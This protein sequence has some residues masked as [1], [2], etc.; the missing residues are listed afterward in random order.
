DGVI[1]FDM[2]KVSMIFDYD[3]GRNSP[4]VEARGMHWGGGASKNGDVI[5]VMFGCLHDQASEWNVDVN[6]EFTL[7]NSDSKK[8]IVA[9]LSETMSESG[10][11]RYDIPLTYRELLDEE[12][13]FIK[14]DTITLE[15]RFWIINMKGIRAVPKLDFT[16][17]NISMHDVTLVIEGEKIYVSKQYLSLH[18]PVFQTMFY[19]EFV[20]KGK[21]EIELKDVKREEFIELLHV[22][23]PSSKKI[24]HESAEFLLKL[25]DR[26]QIVSVINRVEEFLMEHSSF[27]STEKLRIADQF[28]LFGLMNDC[29]SALHDREDFEMI[30][31]LP[32]YFSLSN[33]TKAILFERLLEIT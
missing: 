24:R 26:F 13:G 25:S 7:V 11:F 23:Y 20:E 5:G 8:S 16:D 19:G 2:D 32:F 9:E 10:H 30:K 31:Q 4:I 33:D 6:A 22:M 18:S 17:P 28:R 21:K 1:R 27:D 29:L 14:N 15:I 3:D 12:K